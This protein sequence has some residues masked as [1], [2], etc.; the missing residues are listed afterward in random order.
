MAT[1]VAVRSPE[2]CDRCSVQAYWRFDHDQVSLC[3]C[4]HHSGV[5][6]R[7][8]QEQGFTPTLLVV[9]RHPAGTATR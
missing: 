8:L 4:G 2:S 7:A 5:Y 1:I 6:M 3:F 9:S